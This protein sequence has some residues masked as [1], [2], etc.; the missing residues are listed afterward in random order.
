MTHNI[1]S[2]DGNLRCSADK[3][4]LNGQYM[5]AS[6]ISVTVKSPSHINFEIGDYIVFRGEVYT[7][8][9]I[10]AEKKI[11]EKNSTGNAF[12]YDN[13]KLESCND[14]LS[15]ADFNDFVGS[16]ADVSFTAQPNFSFVAATVNDLAQ[17]IQ[18]NLD[19]YYTGD[20][21]WTIQIAD[22]YV[23]DPDNV[24]KLI[25]VSNIKCWDALALFKS[26]YDINFIIRG[27]TVTIGTD[28]SIKDI[29]F[30]VGSYKGLYDMT[31]NIQADQAIITRLT[32]YGNTTNINPRYYSL[33]SA[34]VTASSKSFIW[35]NA[36]GVKRFGIATDLNS[37]SLFDNITAKVL[38]N[39]YTLPFTR[40]ESI[41]T[42]NAT[43]D[44]KICN[45]YLSKASTKSIKQDFTEA[46]SSNSVTLLPNGTYNIALSKLKIST[47]INAG[48]ITNVSVKV[49]VWVGDMNLVNKGDIQ[50]V[51]SAF[52]MGTQLLIPFTDTSFV[53]NSD[54]TNPRF[55][56]TI[57]PVYSSFTP[58]VNVDYAF[59]T[60][61]ADNLSVIKTDRY[62]MYHIH[63]FT[64]E[65]DSLY[66]EIANILSTANGNGT[67]SNY[68]P[69]T[70]L[71][72]V[73]KESI[74]DLSHITWDPNSKLPNNMNIANLMLPGFPKKTLAQWVEENK[75]N[76]SWLQDYVNQGYTFSNEQFYPYVNSK[77]IAELGIRPS[78][79]CFTS[80][81]STHKDI[82]PSL[83]YFSDN[84]NQVVSVSNIDDTP[85]TDNGL[86]QNGKKAPKIKITIHDLGFNF[87]D[88]IISGTN[89]KIHFEN[90][91]CG[92]KDFTVLSYTAN[93]L[94]LTCDRVKDDALGKYFPNVDS[95][96]SSGDKFVLSSIHMP[97][98]YIEQASIEL[99]KWN[100]KLLAKNDFTVFSYQLSPDSN[101]IKRHDDNI[102]DKSNTFYKTVKEGDLLMI[103]DADMGIY[104][105]VTIDNIKITEDES[106]L[107][108]YDIVLRDTKQVG[109]IQKVQQQIDALSGNGASAGYNN[110]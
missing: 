85:I 56:V 104:S 79:E 13:M 71:S 28:G 19:R 9:N 60:L 24:N 105:S 106:L 39:Q 78:T 70:I 14:E 46:L 66:T 42:D 50:S 98:T 97:D 21:K 11:S 108:K 109:T 72:G 75:A 95:P 58:D 25:T 26:L 40:G 10:P 44:S 69:T 17:R 1:Y 27:R 63:T 55:Y 7:I 18:V 99:L 20:K 57:T 90:G 92:G 94:V 16:N 41:G 83:K 100:L 67:I 54:I 36:N 65:E 30:K 62:Y 74:T 12:Q 96:I 73:D 53:V 37:N 48:G 76:Y 49:K 89:P 47:N 61:D 4:E 64:S 33:I 6:S 87:D 84:R 110:S 38:N 59:N 101:F 15:N 45:L 107:P 3:V 29:T 34:I 31:R 68:A 51:T 80:D 91:Y 2:K 8:K 103:E 35:G 93:N 23:T 77:N 52:G 43:G 32:S 22:G 88:V 81:D 102:V 5:G 82:Y 86:F